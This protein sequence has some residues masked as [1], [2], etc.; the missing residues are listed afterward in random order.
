MK[1][2]LLAMACVVSSIQAIEYEKQYE[3]DHVCVSRVVIMPQEEI[4]L[5]YDVSPQLVIAIKGG[6]LTRFELDGSI[7]EVEFPT[8]TTVFRPAETADKMH[9]TANK[10]SEPIEIIVIALK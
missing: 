1:Y 8:G 10:Q 5:H 4:G 3:N 9:K 2:I 6:I 7:T